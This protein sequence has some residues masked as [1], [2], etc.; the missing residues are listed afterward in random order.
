MFVTGYE[1]VMIPER[2]NDIGRLR[3]PTGC[4]LVVRA[5]AQMGTQR[6]GREFLQAAARDEPNIAS[7]ARP[8]WNGFSQTGTSA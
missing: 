5:A 4:R 8:R 3:K 7:T 6:S 2:F 1:D